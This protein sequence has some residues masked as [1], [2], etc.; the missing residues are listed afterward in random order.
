MDRLVTYDEF[1]NENILDEIN[2]KIDSLWN[3]FQYRDN[4]FRK[5]YNLTTT[6]GWVLFVTFLSIVAYKYFLNPHINGLYGLSFMLLASVVRFIHDKLTKE[7]VEHI[8]SKMKEIYDNMNEYLYKSEIYTILGDTKDIKEYVEKLKYFGIIDDSHILDYKDVFLIDFSGQYENEKPMISHG[9]IDPYNEEDWIDRS[10][11][12]DV[13]EWSNVIKNKAEK[14]SKQYGVK[15][16]RIKDE[17]SIWDD[18]M[19]FKKIGHDDALKIDLERKKRRD[20]EK[21]RKLKG[22]RKKY[23]NDYDNRV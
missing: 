18:T 6:G 20:D 3:N 4:L 10:A 21:L 12:V 1:L 16:R 13:L 9:D 22:I 14:I 17:H 5:L 19:K 8:K 23:R 15:L 2:K 7:K 11:M